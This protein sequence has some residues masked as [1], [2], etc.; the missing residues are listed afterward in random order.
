M[1]TERRIQD[2]VNYLNRLSRDE[3]GDGFIVSS[4][5]F[6][7][8]RLR[9]LLGPLGAN[10]FRKYRSELFNQGWIC[11]K[12]SQYCTG[13]QIWLSFH[14]DSVDGPHVFRKPLGPLSVIRALRVFDELTVEQVRENIGIPLFHPLDESFV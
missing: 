11:L 14:V 2:I 9:E 13:V 10:V 12:M 1:F 4:L 5:P 8:P 6:T 7:K 3:V